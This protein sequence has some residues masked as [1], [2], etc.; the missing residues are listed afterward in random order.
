VALHADFDIQ[1]LTSHLPVTFDKLHS[2]SQQDEVLGTVKEYIKAGW[3]DPNILRQ[4]P[5]WSQIEGFH[6]RRESLTIKKDCIMFGERIIIPTV[7]RQ[8]VLKLMHQGHPGIQRMKSLAQNYT[9]WPG[10]DKDIEQR[11]RRCTPCAAAAKQP[12]KAT[13]HSWPPAIKPW[14]RIHIDY[15]GPH[16][17]KQFPI[18][19]DAYS[20]YPEV[21]SVPSITS[22]QTVAA[23]RK[24]CA[25]KEG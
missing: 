2:I 23:L 20:K 14:E 12:P 5:H 21:V 1:L 10:M 4:H 15:A 9:Y 16:L 6:R 18:V 22:R 11:V 24:M 13:L 25:S 19:I 3:P 17:G 7:L 8:W